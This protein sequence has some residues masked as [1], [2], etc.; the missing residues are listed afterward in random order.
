[1]II[2]AEDRAN[3][4]RQFPLYP[5]LHKQCNTNIKKYYLDQKIESVQ[6]SLAITV[7]SKSFKK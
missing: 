5:T 2:M 4:I 1:M 6:R 7:M 3:V